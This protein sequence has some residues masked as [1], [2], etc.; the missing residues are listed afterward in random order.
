MRSTLAACGSLYLKVL[1]ICIDCPF[2]GANL[3][4]PS[5]R[6]LVIWAKRG[7]GLVPASIP[8]GLEELELDWIGVSGW[9][10]AADLRTLVLRNSDP[11]RELPPMPNLEALSVDLAYEELMPHSAALIRNVADH[12][13]FA[14]LNSGCGDLPDDTFDS[15]RAFVCAEK[16]ELGGVF[17]RPGLS[18]LGEFP[19]A[20]RLKELSVEFTAGPVVLLL[21]INDHTFPQL[22]TALIYGEYRSEDS[23][24]RFV[25]VK[26]A[27]LRSF[28]CLAPADVVLDHCPVL[29][30]CVYA[31]SEHFRSPTPAPQSREQE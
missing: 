13:R 19:H 4:I 15:P 1:A 9:A 7:C 8:A 20:A 3:N 5:L 16:I 23:S 25:V 27:S 28:R 29:R 30:T 10:N 26:H 14:K 2:A 6:K 11:G 21:D 17:T 31:G 22:E 24:H 18:K 12:V